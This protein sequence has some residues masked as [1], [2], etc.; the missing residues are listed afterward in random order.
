MKISR[1]E[2][3]EVST[4][5]VAGSVVAISGRQNGGRR[6]KSLKAHDGKV[7]ALLSQMTLEEKNKYSHRRKAMDK[8]VTFLNQVN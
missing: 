4:L 1:R 2:F 5:T 8:L 6:S 7:R 3:I